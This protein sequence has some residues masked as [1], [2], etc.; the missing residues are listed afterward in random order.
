MNLWDRLLGRGNLSSRQIAKD[1]LQMVLI[2][3]R[4]DLSPG[5]LEALKDEIIA[6]IG[7]RVNVDREKVTFSLEKDGRTARLVADIPLKTGKK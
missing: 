1:R 2:H 4:S 6:T 7:N 3:D 5:M